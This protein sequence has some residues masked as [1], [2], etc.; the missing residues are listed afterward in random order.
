MRPS[1][2]ILGRSAQPGAT[3]LCVLLLASVL[4]A[5]SAVR[6]AGAQCDD[7]IPEI[8]S[9]ASPAVVSL[10]ATS[11][12]P[13]RLSDRVRHVAGSGFFIDAAGLILTNAHVVFNRQSIRATLDD[14]TEVA[15]ELVGADPIFDVAVVRIPKP[16]DGTLTTIPLGDSD[17]VRVGED[18]VAIGNPLGLDQTLTRGVVSAINRILPETPLSLFEPLIQTDTPINPGNSGG[19]LLNRCGEVVGITT[20]LLADAQNI[21]FAVPINLAKAVLPSLLERGRVV[22]PWIGFHGQLIDDTVRDLLRLPLVEGLLVEIIEPGSPAERAGLRGGQLEIAISGREFLFGGDIVTTMNGTR[23]SSDERL[24]EAM[25]AAAVGDTLRLTV[26]R[27][28]EYLTLEYVLPERPLL[29]GDLPG[30]STLVPSATQ[31]RRPARPPLKL[32]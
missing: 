8:F 19:P 6:T 32:P 21:S 7:P 31:R 27:R 10:A 2:S 9:R 16:T 25:R 23:L 24:L 14:G 17:R 3:G 26:Y 4:A 1:R 28:G 15:A 30:Q 13:Y 29:P 12:N 22:R 18:V 5:C 11:I 20:S